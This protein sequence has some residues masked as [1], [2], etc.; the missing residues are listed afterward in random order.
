MRAE[1]DA[2]A[3][4]NARYFICTDVPATWD[5]FLA[6]GRDDYERFVRP[7]LQEHVA[8]SQQKTALEI[9]CGIGRMTRCFAEDFASVFAVDVSS[10]MIAQGRGTGLPRTQWVLGNGGDLAGVPDQGVDFA[11]SYIVF[12]HIP[13]KGIILNYLAELARVLRP[14][15][16]LLVHMNGLP[17]LE[18][19][20]VLLEG[21]IS[22][23]PRLRRVGLRKLPWIRRRPLG[24][25]MGSP[26]ALGDVRSVFKR[27]GLRLLNVRGRWTEHMWV[28]GCRDQGPRAA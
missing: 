9:G 18:I 4:D 13:R 14:G 28:A 10:Q 27:S 20:G 8:D 12:Q 19:L 1:W 24:T 23:S 5:A 2:R 15:G 16:S 6:S 7:F 25:W 22:A 21:Y 17:H 11:F 26:V 3:S